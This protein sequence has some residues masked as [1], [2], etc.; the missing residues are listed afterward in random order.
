MKASRGNLSPHSHG[1]DLMLCWDRREG[2]FVERARDDALLSV[3]ILSKPSRPDY[4]YT[5]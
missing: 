4:I 3:I 2:C 1:F 5:S